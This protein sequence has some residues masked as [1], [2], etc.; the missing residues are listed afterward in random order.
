MI[1]VS[2]SIS[3]LKSSGLRGIVAMWIVSSW[4]FFTWGYCS[5]NVVIG[6]AM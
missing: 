1:A 5:S 6:I 3:A 4:P 2:S